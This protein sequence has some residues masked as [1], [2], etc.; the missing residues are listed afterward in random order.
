MHEVGLHEKSCLAA[1]GAADYQHVLIPGGLG[2]F[3]PVVHGEPF[4]LGQEDVVVK[5]GVDI[6]G[7]ILGAAPSGRAVFLALAVF[8]GVLALAVHHQPQGGGTG[9]ADQQVK[10]V[11]AGGG[12][13]KCRRTAVH[14]VQQL[15][16]QVHACRQ[17]VCLPQLPEQVNENQVREIGQDELFYLWFHS[18]IPL[19]LIF[20]LARCWL[21]AAVFCFRADRALR[22][23]G[24][25]SRFSFLAV[26]S[27]N[28]CSK[29]SACLVLKIT[30]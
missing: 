17:P 8:L 14:E 30:I 9:D 7:Y 2:V 18:D 1:A 26:N 29:L 20:S 5:V 10:G 22:I 27:L 15:F 19:S 6:G 23:E 28:A 25:S 21:L 16:G 11:D 4:R 12:V 3:G 13:G 24:R